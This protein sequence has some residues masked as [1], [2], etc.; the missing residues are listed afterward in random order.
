[1][2]DFALTLSWLTQP[3]TIIWVEKILIAIWET[4]YMTVVSMTLSY[5]VGLP[6]GI[7]LVITS[8]GHISEQLPL[9]RSLG[10]VINALRSLPFII[11]MI[12]IIP[13]TRLLVGTS[14]GTTAT[15]VPL[16]VAAIPFV[17]RL[18]E[19]SLNEIE[20]GLI[21]AALAM[22]ASK[23]QVI[24]RVLVPEAMP[25]LLRGVSITAINLIGYSAM[26][27]I[28]GGGGLGTLAYYYGY[29][30]YMFTILLITVALLIVL[31]QGLQ[32]I[33]DAVVDKATKNRR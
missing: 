18:V 28:V 19:S 9:N 22:G 13:F 1:M 23:M 33:G 29:Q 10:A 30:R 20:W 27:G 16:T 17:A 32:A 7:I 5:A 4:I 2:F 25:S 15:I 14:I 24:T 31:V 3:D 8:R 12:F 21:E 26:A 6:L 11:L